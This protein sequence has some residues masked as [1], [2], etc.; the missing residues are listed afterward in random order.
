MVVLKP[1]RHGDSWGDFF[2]FLTIW[3]AFASAALILSW[4]VSVVSEVAQR[5]EQRR[6]QEGPDGVLVLADEVLP[7]LA[8]ETVAAQDKP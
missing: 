3:A 4:F 8:G 5:G 6:L 2:S 1:A 7:A